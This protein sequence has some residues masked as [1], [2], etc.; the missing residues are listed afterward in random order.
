M[1]DS[2]A[3]KFLLILRI[4]N[5]KIME[6]FIKPKAEILSEESLIPDKNTISPPPNQFTHK[7]KDSQSFYYIGAMQGSPPDGEF[8]AGTKV[9][10]LRYDGG[11]YCRVADEQGLYAEIQFDSLKEL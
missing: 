8:P 3:E 7:L 5:P 4:R 9:V 10:L 11:S 6:Q 1:I 2:D